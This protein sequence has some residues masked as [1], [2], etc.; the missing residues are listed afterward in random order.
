MKAAPAASDTL[1]ENVLKNDFLPF[2]PGA[3]RYYR[4]IGISIPDPLAATN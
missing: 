4:E 1:P 3:V 2:H